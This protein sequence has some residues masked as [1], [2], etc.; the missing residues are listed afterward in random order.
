MPATPIRA[1]EVVDLVEE[2]AMPTAPIRTRRLGSTSGAMTAPATPIRAPAVVDLE[3]EEAMPT[4]SIRAP[5]V[6]DI[7]DEEAMPTTPI[8]T[9]LQ[10]WQRCQLP[11]Q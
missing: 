5:A 4:T 8:R 9:P 11:E 1:P 2:G 6:G 3:E 7:E 10:R